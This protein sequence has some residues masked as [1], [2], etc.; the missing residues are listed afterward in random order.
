MEANFCINFSEQCIKAKEYAVYDGV[1][2]TIHTWS[3]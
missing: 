1:I 2:N 3:V